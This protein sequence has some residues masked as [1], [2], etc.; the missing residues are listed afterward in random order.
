M[1]FFPPETTPASIQAAICELYKGDHRGL[2][3]TTGPNGEIKPIPPLGLSLMNLA[4]KV[5]EAPTVPELKKYWLERGRIYFEY[6]NSIMGVPVS[7]SQN[8][9]WYANKRTGIIL[10]FDTQNPNNVKIKRTTKASPDNPRYESICDACT[11]VAHVLPKLIRYINDERRKGSSLEAC[12]QL[13]P[14]ISSYIIANSLEWE[15]QQATI[16]RK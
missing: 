8:T 12:E 10:E 1:G 7:A 2:T 6:E 11:V 16:P 14:N 13:A 9:L 5:T 3:V 4:E 15:L